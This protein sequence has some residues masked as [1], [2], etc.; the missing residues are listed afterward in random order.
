MILECQ[1]GNFAVIDVA[2][3]I[4]VGELRYD[5]PQVALPDRLTAQRAERIRA[6]CPA[7]Y[8]DEFHVAP[9]NANNTMCAGSLIARLKFEARYSRARQIA[10]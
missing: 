4:A 8:Q 10:V 7:I 9:V 3:V 5:I 6:G 1:D 2:L